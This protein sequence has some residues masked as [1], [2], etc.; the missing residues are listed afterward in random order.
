MGT[1]ID[2]V[3]PVDAYMARSTQERGRFGEGIP[4]PRSWQPALSWR[5]LRQ[6]SS[7]ANKPPRSPGQTQRANGTLPAC[8]RLPPLS[9]G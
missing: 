2:M 4:E 8:L 9:S 1:F 3:M 6:C 7:R 5:D